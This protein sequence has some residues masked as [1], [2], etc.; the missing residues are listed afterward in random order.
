VVDG[1][2][3]AAKT[4]DPALAGNAALLFDRYTRMHFPNNDVRR[5]NIAERYDPHT[6]ESFFGNL[7]YNHSSWID[8]VVQHVAGIT[9]QESDEILIDPVDMGWES[10]SLTNIRFPFL[11]KPRSLDRGADPLI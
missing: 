7:D 8:L 4:L 5:P 9:P 2:L 11:G 3:W 1:L 6:A 10:F